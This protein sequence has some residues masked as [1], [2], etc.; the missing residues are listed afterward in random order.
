MSSKGRYSET[1][2]FLPG[3]YN[4]IASAYYPSENKDLRKI[5]T[6][7]EDFSDIDE[8][9]YPKQTKHRVPTFH[10][11]FSDIDEHFYP[12]QTKHRVPTF[13]KDFNHSLS[14]TKHMN[15]EPEE[16]FEFDDMK[17]FDNDFEPEPPN[18]KRK[19]GTIGG[20]K[21]RRRRKKS[22]RSGKKS[23]RSGKKSRR[24]H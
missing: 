20:K 5:P 12:K 7:D 1:P 21:S 19:L 15:D 23:R 4:S 24:Y 16:E 14:K 18:K 3:K 6:F 11:D 17:D 22:R 9:F 10:E 8:H 2:G 13:D